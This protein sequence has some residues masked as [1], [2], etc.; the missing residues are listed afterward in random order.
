MLYGKFRA[1]QAGQTLEGYSMLVVAD[2]CPMCMGALLWAKLDKID[3]LFHRD[4]VKPY[5]TPNLGRLYAPRFRNK[6]ELYDQVHC[7]DKMPLGFF[8]SYQEAALDVYRKWSI[9]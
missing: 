7:C 8:K 6:Q 2:P 9:V 4:D 3:F 5:E 1:R